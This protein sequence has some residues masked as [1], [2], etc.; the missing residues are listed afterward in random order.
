MVLRAKTYPLT[1]QNLRF[2]L[3]AAYGPCMKTINEQLKIIL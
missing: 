2:Y 1:R 3:T